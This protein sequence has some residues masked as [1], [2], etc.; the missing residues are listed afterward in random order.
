MVKDFGLATCVET[1]PANE[2]KTL[3]WERWREEYV[4]LS[5]WLRLYENEENSPMQRCLYFSRNDWWLKTG[6]GNYELCEDTLTFITKNTRY[7]F[8]LRGY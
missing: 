4:G 7:V 1:K 3:T 5:G 8:L 6:Y 2:D